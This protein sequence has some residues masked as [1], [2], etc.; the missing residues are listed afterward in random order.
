MV[1]SQQEWDPDV[2][3]TG[4]R[5]PRGGEQAR[6]ATWILC[7]VPSLPTGVGLAAGPQVREGPGGGDPAGRGAFALPLPGVGWEAGDRSSLT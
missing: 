7:W 5:R 2:P 1:S 4:G 6:A 3:R